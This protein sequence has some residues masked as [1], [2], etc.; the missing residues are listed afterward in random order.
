MTST[1]ETAFDPARRRLCP[2]GACVG[3]IGDD[4]RCKVCGTP[5]GAERDPA[6][7]DSGAI[8]WDSSGKDE[9][10]DMTLPRTLAD[11]ARLDDTGGFNPDRQ[12]CSDGDCLGVIGADG[13]CNVCGKPAA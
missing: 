1:D 4:G 8:T 6:A 2:D 5:A 12:L 10:D 3:L 7:A 9:N 11:V 13:H